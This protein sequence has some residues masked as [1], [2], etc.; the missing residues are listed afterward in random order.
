MV[1]LCF[2]SSTLNIVCSWKILGK[3]TFSSPDS[4]VMSVLMEFSSCA[5][6]II[7]TSFFF[8]LEH[9][10]C[11]RKSYIYTQVLEINDFSSKNNTR[12]FYSMVES[13]QRKP[14]TNSVLCILARPVLAGCHFRLTGS[15]TASFQTIR[16]KLAA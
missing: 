11:S 10:W 7:F 1:K 9:K 8:K 16:V 15:H 12:I 4:K 14:N 2:Y 5:L 3:L 6:A 13:T